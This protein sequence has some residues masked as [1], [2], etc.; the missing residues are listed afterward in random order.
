MSKEEIKE[1]LDR[2]WESILLSVKKYKPFPVDRFVKFV[3][4][5]SCRNPIDLL[6]GFL[7]MEKEND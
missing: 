1:M 5:S 7:E 2:Y 4:S 3:D 6:N